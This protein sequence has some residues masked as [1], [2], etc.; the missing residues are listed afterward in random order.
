M[1]SGSLQEGAQGQGGCNTGSRSI[2]QVAS[3]P[4]PL[5]KDED[6]QPQKG[7]DNITKVCEVFEH[8]HPLKIKYWQKKKK[9]YWHK[10]L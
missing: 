10:V 3:P 8:T 6:T 1:M 4:A 9:K 7:T 2:E 5:Q